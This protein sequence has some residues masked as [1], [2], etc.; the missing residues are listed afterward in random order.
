M[1]SCSSS[2]KGGAGSSSRNDETHINGKNIYTDELT[3]EEYDTV[4]ERA[5]ARATAEMEEDTRQLDNVQEQVDAWLAG[6]SATDYLGEVTRPDGEKETLYLE[7]DTKKSLVDNYLKYYNDYGGD[8][9][10]SIAVKYKDGTVVFDYDTERFKLTG[11]D[12]IIVEGGWGTTYS[13]K[14]KVTHDTPS[15]RWDI[16]EDVF[17]TVNVGG[18]KRRLPTYNGGGSIWH[19]DFEE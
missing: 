5:M 11:I 7:R 3:R 15:K 12:T 6:K 4:Y 10:T 2:G 17:R 1:G 18:S 19:V 9:D 16:G 8:E 13:G 14:V